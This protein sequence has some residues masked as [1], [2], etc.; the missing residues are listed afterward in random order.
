[1]TVFADHGVDL[2]AFIADADAVTG[3]W[4]AGATSIARGFVGVMAARAA[5]TT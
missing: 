2:A 3:A 5:A 1:M 4:E